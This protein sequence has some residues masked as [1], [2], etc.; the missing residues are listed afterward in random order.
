MDDEEF[1]E[2]V[3][4]LGSLRPEQR[5]AIVAACGVLGGSGGPRGAGE[6]LSE[7]PEALWAAYERVAARKGLRVP[8]I[9]VARRSGSWAAYERA[10]S[11]LAPWIEEAFVP[12]DETAR[13]AAWN[14]VARTVFRYLDDLGLAPTVTTLLQQAANG[15]A[16]V[17][18]QFPGYAEAGLL[19]GVLR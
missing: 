14:L 16:C 11:D 13:L 4:R 19:R 9:A 5:A 2:F 18:R 7:P 1:R 6:G 17:D 3:G 8:P 10:C 15:T 12:R